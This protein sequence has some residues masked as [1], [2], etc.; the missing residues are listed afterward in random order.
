MSAESSAANIKRTIVPI[1][2]KAP[3]I[4]AKYDEG[5]SKISIA[6]RH[7][8][9]A[10]K[11][12][13][14]SES[15]VGKGKEVVVGLAKMLREELRV[16]G[17]L[18]SELSRVIHNVL[19]GSH[20]VG[21]TGARELVTP[22]LR[23]KLGLIF[24]E[25]SYRVPYDK[26]SSIVSEKGIPPEIA[27]IVTIAATSHVARVIDEAVTAAVVQKD[28]V[29]EESARQSLQQTTEKIAT[30]KA[31][32]GEYETKQ[33]ELQGD[34][35]SKE[36][37]AKPLKDSMSQIQAV[38]RKTC[39][40]LP[41]GKINELTQRLRTE[42]AGLQETGLIFNKRVEYQP[43][44]LA[45]I[46]KV[47]TQLMDAAGVP[48]EPFEAVGL[49]NAGNALI[50]LAETHVQN[51]RDI[52]NMRPQ[53]LFTQL[54]DILVHNYSYGLQPV[55]QSQRELLNKLEKQ[56]PEKAKQY[57][58]D[59]AVRTIAID[60]AKRGIGTTSQSK[61]SLGDYAFTQT[62]NR[63]LNDIVRENPEQRTIL[64]DVD[65]T[66]QARDQGKRAIEEQRKALELLNKTEEEQKQH[67]SSLERMRETRRQDLK[68]PILAQVLTRAD[69]EPI[70]PDLIKR[71]G[72]IN[73]SHYLESQIMSDFID[74]M[75]KGLP[76][77]VAKDDRHPE[78]V[79]FLPTLVSAILPES[80]S[81]SR[82]A[83]Y[84]V[85]DLIRKY[86]KYLNN[87]R[88]MSNN[89]ISGLN[90]A[91]EVLYEIA[92]GGKVTPVPRLGSDG[93]NQFIRGLR[94]PRYYIVSRY[95]LMNPDAHGEHGSEAYSIPSER[96]AKLGSEKLL[97][98]LLSTDKTGGFYIVERK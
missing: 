28:T 13:A 14:V 62:L 47:I 30:Q 55:L 26:T 34:A 11:T 91:S 54:E 76:H 1:L 21:M 18:Y 19:S 45:A 95:N 52:Q 50:R 43:Q 37:R 6:P 38:L 82:D 83:V 29:Y 74:A 4:V 68:N 58:L 57:T 63:N 33:S 16:P 25:G 32:I 56:D 87:R 81:R 88:V 93:L 9:E 61:Y 84:L 67:V 71:N 36:A 35:A 49:Q 41:E 96:V 75:F 8:T 46:D 60:I 39:G 73:S 65:S 24:T 86:P 94:I 17:V 12:H 98:S 31:S 42:I 72:G 66:R 78:V 97:T 89:F 44:R 27:E 80:N 59:L 69:G 3:N 53:D 77:F 64:D 10:N 2:D 48:A 22:I 7:I 15:E 70:D 40:H 20:P 5:T 85:C 51:N 79:D 90:V 92:R 23:N